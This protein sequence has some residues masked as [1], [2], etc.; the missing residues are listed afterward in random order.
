M[1]RALE[2][3]AR[4]RGRTAPNPM[5][6]AVVVAGDEVVG[7]GYHARAGEPHA[8]TLALAAAGDAARGA[9]L[10]VTLEPCAHHGRT[11]PCVDAIVDAGVSRVFAAM[12]DPN[13]LVDGRGLAR[14]REAGVQVKTGMLGDEAARLNEVYCKHVTTGLPHVTLKIGMSLDGKT[15]TRS[16]DARWIT[17]EESRRRVHELRNVS[18]AVLVGIGTILAD[19][20][21]LTTRLPGVECRHPE[22]VVIDSHL[23]IP[24]KARVLAHGT[25]GR[26]ILVAGPNAPQARRRELRE[27]GAEVIVVDGGE[28]RVEMAAVMGRLGAMGITSVLVE[29]GSEIAASC[30]DAGVVDTLVF[31]IAPLIIGGRDAPPVIGGRGAGPLAEALRLRDMR[32][33]SAGEDLVVEARLREPSCLP[34]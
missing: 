30:L 25:K 28:R 31:F 19:D 11:P 2:L 29:G 22:R 14:L 24:N 1:A 23:R 20:P 6:G 16:G 3:A 21:D 34:A 10:Y 32:W 15:A 18:D 9:D 27:L 12:R 8:E 17:G 5:V 26:T 33:S 4:A 7:E 13:P